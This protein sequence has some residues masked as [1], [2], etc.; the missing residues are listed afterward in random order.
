MLDKFLYVVNIDDFLYFKAL[1][2][3]LMLLL[4]TL[5]LKSKYR[6]FDRL[7]NRFSLLLDDIRISSIWNVGQWENYVLK[8]ILHLC[9]FGKLVKC[10]IHFQ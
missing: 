1:L 4:S 9:T 2:T 8:K 3:C 6:C 10:E 7:F 5:F